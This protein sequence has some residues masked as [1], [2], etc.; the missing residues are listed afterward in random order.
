MATFLQEW[1]FQIQGYSRNIKLFLVFN[2]VW[3]LGLGMFG[4]IYNLYV[5]ALG[6]N[7]YTIGHIVGMTALASA[8]VLVPA[9]IMNDRFGPKRIIS[10]G[11]CLVIPALI[12]RSLLTGE[13]ML[14]VSAFI[15]GMSLA[16]VSAT[17]MPF[18]ANNSKPEQ[19]IH[20]FSLNMALMMVANVIG[21][22]LGGWLSDFFQF[23]I[24]LKEIASIRITLLAGISIASLGLIPVMLFNASHQDQGI[25]QVRQ[26]MPWKVLLKD[27]KS[28]FQVIGAFAF[29]GLLSSTSGGMIVPYLNV[30]FEDRFHASKTTIGVIVALGQGATAVAFLIGP[31]LARKFG[32]VKSVLIVQ[33][34]SIPFLLI[35]AYST[36]F[37]LASGGYLFRQA[38]MNAS[39][40]FLNS[41]KM[42]YVH[43]SLRG[44]AS[45]SGEAM[46]NLGWFLAAPIS[47]GLVVHYGSYFGYAYAFSITAVGYILI[48]VLFY[49]FFGKNRFKAVEENKH[50]VVSK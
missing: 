15:A 7:Q 42:R 2:L 33:F 13:H 25:Q 9:G 16:V 27:H 35:T 45:S 11:L 44:L 31:L 46:F 3:N 10:I 12:A 22:A 17:L 30:Y 48:T 32:E 20:L 26:K 50:P 28:S 36:N 40:P 6:Y 47:T 49:L 21:I 4:L 23:F 41:I 14:I 38:L 34:G 29:I 18:M 43:R 8:I 24:G 39:S 1:K 19:R 37:Y 5:K